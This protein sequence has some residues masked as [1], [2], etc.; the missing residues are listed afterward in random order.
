MIPKN[1]VIKVLDYIEM[2]LRIK[3]KEEDWRLPDGE[4]LVFDEVW[5]LINNIR[6]E[7]G[8]GDDKF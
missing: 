7:Y 6:K 2:N 1:E 4:W 5:A 8:G 3:T